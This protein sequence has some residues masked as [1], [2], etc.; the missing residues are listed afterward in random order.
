MKN[1]LI[2]LI[3]FA[4][5]L[6]LSSFRVNNSD[7]AP[8]LSGTKWVASGEGT[9]EAE[10][11]G[12]PFTF[13]ETLSFTSDSTFFGLYTDSFGEK[14]DPKIGTYLY[15]HPT[16]TLTFTEEVDGNKEIFPGT[17]NGNTMAFS[18]ITFIRQ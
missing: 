17:I 3:V 10:G 1:R 14:S 18:G 4:A 11:G 15:S 7:Q 6:L 5:L 13:T 8:T 16:I 12:I 2:L 9:A